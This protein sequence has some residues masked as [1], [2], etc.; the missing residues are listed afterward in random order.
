MKNIKTIFV[1]LF[2]VT[3]TTF[4]MHDHPKRRPSYPTKPVRKSDDISIQ[5]ASDQ[6]YNNPLYGKENLLSSEKKGCDCCC[7][8][9][10]A[11]FVALYLY[12]FLY[13]LP[14]SHIKHGL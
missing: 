5:I 1:L 9:G 8:M 3:T 12:S 14:Q 10:S 2:V 6:L 7:F 11:S 4:G 13:P